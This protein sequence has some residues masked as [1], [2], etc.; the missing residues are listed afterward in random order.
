MSSAAT[1]SSSPQQVDVSG[2]TYALEWYDF[3]A[4]TPAELK[5]IEHVYATIFRDD[6]G[7][8]F[9]ASLDAD[10]ITPLA[11]YGADARGAFM[12]V[13]RSD[14]TIV[15]TVALRAQPQLENTCELKRMFFL[16]ECR[17]KGLAPAAMAMV[18]ERA[19]ALRYAAVV[20]DT[21]QKLAAANALYYRTGFADCENY[22]GNPRADR[23]MRYTLPP[24]ASVDA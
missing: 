24:L 5:S 22:N 16:P 17:G 21:K 8:V 9:D 18:L 7:L 11:F 12:V 19:A 1:S 13:R 15:G 23:F 14:A 4:A 2:L 3:A 20:L 6:I 10:L